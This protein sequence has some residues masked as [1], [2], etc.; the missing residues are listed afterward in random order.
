MERYIVSNIQRH[1]NYVVVNLQ[2]SS[3]DG[4]L[5]FFPGQYAAISFRRGS[6]WSPARCFSMTNSPSANEL[7]FATRVEGRFTKQLANLQRGDTVNVQGPFGNFVIDPSFDRRIVM[8][9][10][11]IG[12]TPFMSMLRHASEIQLES[13]ITLL[14]AC[15]RADD[16]PFYDEIQALAHNN[17]RLRVFFLVAEG[18]SDQSKNIFARR[19]DDDLL[20][21]VTG[22]NFGA[23]SFFLCGPK[24]FTDNVE[25]LLQARDVDEDH[26]ITESFT[27]ATSLGLGVNISIP[28]LTYVTTAFALLAGI[29]F[30]TYLDLA[31]YLPKVQAKASAAS[32]TDNTAAPS[33]TSTTTNSSASQ[34]TG[35][36]YSQTTNS[37]TSS[38]PTM[39]SYSQSYQAP[40]SSVS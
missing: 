36:S 22:E 8:L 7:Q 34:S 4:R 29:G 37:S 17:P 31:R 19:I 26:L 15:R 38:A 32:S 9:A 10:G 13:P 25:Q 21:K 39:Q 2:P 3:E 14:Y 12:I 16:I 40:V 5:R 30:F 35:D 20:S 6:K 28:S 33:T 11:G 18:F 23:Y 27:Q 1:G 24:G